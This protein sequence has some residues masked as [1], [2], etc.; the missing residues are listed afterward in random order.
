MR[1]TMST[2]RIICE[3]SLALNNRTGKFF[4]LDNAISHN[5]DLVSAVRF[6]RFSSRRVPQ[7]M[8]A[9]ILGRGM[10]W[11]LRSRSASPILDKLL[12][13]LQAEEPVLFTDP[14]QVLFYDLKKS[15]LVVVH[16]LGTITHPALYASGV[17]E[18][19]SRAFRDIK[20]SLCGLIFVS[21]S[22]RSAFANLYG[23]EGQEAHIIFNPIRSASVAGSTSVPAGVRQPYL[24]T[25]G[26]VGMRKNQAAVARA[27]MASQLPSLGWQYVISGGPEP[28]FS[29]VKRFAEGHTEIRL[30]GYSSDQ[31]LRWLYA[32]A[33]GF[34]LASHLE[35]F[36][37]PA[38]ECL[39]NGLVPVLSRD[40]AL[41][42]VAGQS[43]IYVDANSE[44]S[45]SKGLEDLAE[46][47][48]IQRKERLSRASEMLFKLDEKA[49]LAQWRSLFMSHTS[50]GH[51]AASPTAGQR[52][53]ITTDAEIATK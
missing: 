37:M 45:I 34:V 8:L 53:S 52:S 18:F 50:G 9:K 42:E 14:L 39:Q 6:W 41:M 20:R 43:A 31:E 22:A 47:T 26:A 36:G 44:G 4:A 17:N 28:G 29:D 2:P 25:V 40:P 30:L 21:N 35:G 48:D 1:A 13:R 16:D 46:L 51:L 24:L 15:D 5:L 27:F 49:V 23:L 38:A 19:Y 3:F 10:S 7:G 33:A 32:N 11:E 12:P